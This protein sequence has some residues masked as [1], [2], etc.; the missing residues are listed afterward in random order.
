[1]IESDLKLI[2][3]TQKTE[4]RS[5]FPA[6]TS[7]I[8]AWLAPSSSELKSRATCQPSVARTSTVME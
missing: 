8:S 3:S 5:M 7:L 1:M 2:F 6:P 4:V